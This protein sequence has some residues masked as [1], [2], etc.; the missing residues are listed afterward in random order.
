MFQGNTILTK[1]NAV[2]KKTLFEN[3]KSETEHADDIY[4][5]TMM[6]LDDVDIRSE[7]PTIFN[8]GTLYVSGMRFVPKKIFNNVINHGEIVSPLD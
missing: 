2:V 6:T 3:N 5:K 8:E 4:N 7:G 1:K